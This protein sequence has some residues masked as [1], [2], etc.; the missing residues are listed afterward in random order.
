MRPER[1]SSACEDGCEAPGGEW[2]KISVLSGSRTRGVQRRGFRELGQAESEQ[3]AEKQDSRTG[4]CEIEGC[5]MLEK[6]WW[7]GSG[8]SRG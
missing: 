8:R 6:C 2:A 1:A 3:G 4:R 7:A 5:Y